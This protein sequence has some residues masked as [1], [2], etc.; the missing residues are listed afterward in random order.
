MSTNTQAKIVAIFGGEAVDS[1]RT[2]EI[3]LESLKLRF[4]QIYPGQDKIQIV[5]W[6]PN[7]GFPSGEI[8]IFP[9]SLA[10]EEAVKVRD[11]HKS[12]RIVVLTDKPEYLR[13][14][15]DEVGITVVDKRMLGTNRKRFFGAILGIPEE[16][17]P[18]D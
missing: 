10:W 2:F 17:I 12:A 9:T 15:S 16:A 11:T 13:L 1:P 14:S 6:N 3:F 8:F 4:E 7:M 5:G 18:E